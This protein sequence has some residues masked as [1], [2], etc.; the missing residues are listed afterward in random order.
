MSPASDKRDYYEVLGVPKNAEPDGIKRAYRKIAL[1]YHPDKNPGNQEAEERFKDAAEAYEVLSDT[2]KRERYDRFG[3]AGV[4]GQGRQFT[5]FEEVFSAFGDIFGGGGSIFEEF[6]GGGRRGQRA[7]RGRGA[8]L[9]VDLEVT[10]A[11][12][13]EG[14][15][16]TIEITRNEVCATC[17]GT[18]AKQ[19]TRPVRCTE[20]GGRGEIVRSQGFF[21]MRS[22][23]PRCHGTGEVIESPCGECGGRGRR[24]E[25]REIT[26]NI[27]PGVG[28]GTPLRVSGEGEAGPRGG[29]RGD[30]FCEIHVK[31]HPFFVRHGDDLLL[32]MPIGFAQAALGAEIEVPTLQGKSRLKIPRGTASGTQLRMRGMGVPSL[33]GYGVGDQLV[34]VVVEVPTKL[35]KEHEEVLRRYAELEEQNVGAK[36]R[37]FL[38]K[39][40]E[41][42][43]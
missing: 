25:K 21:A 5:S 33:D 24:P 2:E 30:L 27:P 26:V 37:S 38:D 15:R 19:G 6:F 1:R 20:C 23:C 10:L 14:T 13:G 3:F 41:L 40:R 28:H 43:E 34:R 8:H 35:D 11:E 22:T 9:K 32:E 36:R 7:G 42:F 39:V 12:V 17:R 16:K 4:G 31:R 18:G 29:S